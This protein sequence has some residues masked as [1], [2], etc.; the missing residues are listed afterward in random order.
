[1]AVPD[2]ETVN[3]PDKEV[4]KTIVNMG[5]AL[6]ERSLFFF[7]FFSMIAM[8]DGSMNLLSQE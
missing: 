8:Q 6:G 7:F 5:V 2:A 1:M 3:C 4:Y